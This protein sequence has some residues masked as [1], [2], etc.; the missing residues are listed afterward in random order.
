MKPCTQGVCAPK[1]LLALDS[2]QVANPK[3]LMRK[4]NRTVVVWFVIPLEVY[5]RAAYKPATVK[6]R[7]LPSKA[8][9]S[10]IQW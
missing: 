5:L 1:N 8:D 6:K 3:A 10:H 4:L 2:R 9:L 7:N